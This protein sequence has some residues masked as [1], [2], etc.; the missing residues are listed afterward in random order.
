MARKNYKVNEPIKVYYQAPDKQSG[1]L[2]VKCEVFDAQDLIDSTRSGYMV[3]VGSSGRYNHIFTPDAEGDW[4]VQIVIE[5]TG[6]GAVTK[7]FSV[8][9]YNIQEIGANL[10]SV[11]LK[12]IELKKSLSSPPMVG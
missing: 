1:L 11:E 12:V 4:S 8:G 9:E 7:H 2:D 6:S 10:Q 5:S 3:E